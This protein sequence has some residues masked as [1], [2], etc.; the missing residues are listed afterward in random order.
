MSE[1]GEN[2]LRESLGLFGAV[3]FG[4]G[5]MIGAG[6]FALSGLLAVKLG[7]D[8]IL[9]IFIAGLT[10][11]STGYIYGKFSTVVVGS[12]GGFSYT[13]TILRSK[14]AFLT[15][16]WFFLA[17][18]VAGAFYAGVFGLYVEIMT[19]FDHLTVS[20]FVII[21]FFVLNY[22][23][24]E[25][26]A[27]AESFL[28]M[29][30]LVVLGVIV[31]FGYINIERIPFN[32]FFNHGLND[33]L[34]YSATIFI[35]FEGFDIIAT[36]SQEIKDPKRNVIRAIFYSV[37]IVTFIYIT[38]II[39]DIIIV[40]SLHGNFNLYEEI[41]LLVAEDALGKIG[42]LLLMSGAI[43]STLSAY[44]A[45]LTA[46]SRVAF[47]LSKEKHFPSKLNSVRGDS[48]SPYVAVAIA[49][50]IISFTI[51][52][53]DLFYDIKLVSFT[54]GKIS[55][56]AFLLSFILVQYAFLKHCFKKDFFDGTLFNYLAGFIAMFFSGI[57]TIIIVLSDIKVLVLYILLT[58]FGFV[59][60][61]L[62]SK[63]LN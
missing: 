28:T 3:M 47:A 59:I 39:L 9:S 60:E 48:G 51:V 34:I 7:W 13:K 23:G 42:Y 12:G 18:S 29:F 27:K 37:I 56:L 36:L 24:I 32:G 53:A 30:K 21:I 25:E 5:G 8:A 45:T 2:S 16:W 57:F 38:I 43:V 54:L 58:I 62:S 15:G 55:S 14:T 40:E 20:I 6:V 31:F 49:S 19:G 4:I 52:Y 35:A 11:I 61:F 50:F 10:S 41:V 63:K 1:K 33:I 46:G 22:I 17:Y 26:S 44:N